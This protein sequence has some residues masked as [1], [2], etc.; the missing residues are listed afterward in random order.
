MLI[1]VV[2]AG[3]EDSRNVEDEL[4]NLIRSFRRTLQANRRVLLQRSWSA[5][6]PRGRW[7]A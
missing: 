1:E 4:R 3:A 2:A 6:T 5:P 7:S